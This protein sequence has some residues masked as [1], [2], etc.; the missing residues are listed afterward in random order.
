MG[1]IHCFLDIEVD[2][3]TPDVNSVLGPGFAAS[4]EDERELDVLEINADDARGHAALY[5]NARRR[6]RAGGA[7]AVLS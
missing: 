3:P 6:V 7:G 5:F 4:D 2:G 1:L